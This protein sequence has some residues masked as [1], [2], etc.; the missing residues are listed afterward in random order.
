[1]VPISKRYSGGPR[2]S[3]FASAVTWDVADAP[4]GD[5]GDADADADAGLGLRAGVL[6][7]CLRFLMP[8][9]SENSSGHRPRALKW[10]TAQPAACWRAAFLEPKS[11]VA[12]LKGSSWSSRVRVQDQRSPDL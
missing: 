1:M 10:A 3:R 9:T 5:A 12:E 2:L 8:P 4:D 11:V 6:A 7:T